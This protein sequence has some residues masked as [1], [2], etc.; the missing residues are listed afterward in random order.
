M[1]AIALVRTWFDWPD[2]ACG[3]PISGANTRQEE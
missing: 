1:V 2:I 3:E